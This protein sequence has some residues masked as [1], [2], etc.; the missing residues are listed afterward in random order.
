MNSIMMNLLAKRIF[1]SKMKKR[2]GRFES[3][4]KFLAVSGWQKRGW[5]ERKH[6]FYQ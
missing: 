4:G 5:I 2:M 1:V 3:E 6:Q